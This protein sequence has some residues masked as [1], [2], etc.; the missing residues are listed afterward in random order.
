MDL[1]LLYT[2]EDENCIKRI[3]GLWYLLTE[4]ELQTIRNEK[5]TKFGF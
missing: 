3:K 4:D 5:W 1:F 2:N